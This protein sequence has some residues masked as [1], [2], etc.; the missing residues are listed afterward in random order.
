MALEDDLKTRSNS[1]CE[2]CN[3]TKGLSPF[4]ITPRDGSEAA[5]CIYSCELCASQINDPSSVDKHH[6]TCLNESAWSQEPA[7]QVVAWRMLNVLNQESWAQDLLGQ[8]YLDDATLAW[9]QTGQASAGTDDGLIHR[10]C[11]GA[12]LAAG[13]SVTLIKD[14]NVKGGGFTAKRGTMVRGISL[15]AD[16]AGHIEGRVSGQQIVILTEFVKKA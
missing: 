6:W 2:I 11:N 5:D 9:A 8:I 14:L 4:A 1:V 7:V 10:D 15:V 3:A 12:V 16:N 13:D